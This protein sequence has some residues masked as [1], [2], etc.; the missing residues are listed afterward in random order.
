MLRTAVKNGSGHITFWNEALKKL[1]K[2][3]FIK[4]G[5]PFRPPSLKNLIKTIK[6][7][8]VLFNLLQKNGFAHMM[9]RNFNQDPLENLFG[10]IRQRGVSWTNP[11]VQAFTPILKS[12]LVKN[13]TSHSLGA[14]CEDDNSEIFLSLQRFVT[15]VWNIEI[16]FDFF[17]TNFS[18]MFGR[19]FIL[20]NILGFARTRR[21][22]SANIFNSA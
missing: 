11:T 5:Q 17:I 22:L 21:C 19:L 14:N 18:E 16:Y 9:P 8:K 2:I 10:Q 3:R 4:N 13:L 6:N 7:F 20:V 12:L 1:E 15:Q